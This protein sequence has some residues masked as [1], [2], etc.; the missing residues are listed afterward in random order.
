MDMNEAARQWFDLGLNIVPQNMQVKHPSV[1]WK[2]LQY[3]RVTQAELHGWRR[4]FCQGIGVICGAIS[5]LIVVDFDDVENGLALLAECAQR[6]GPI[7]KTRTVISGSGRGF[8]LHFAHPGY[9]V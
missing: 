4:K 5:N 9:E 7:P 8:H 3:R 1:R 2:E 6:F